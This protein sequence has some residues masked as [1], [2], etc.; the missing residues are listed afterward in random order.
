MDKYNLQF[1][2][3]YGST[4]TYLSVARIESLALAHGITV[5]WHPFSVKEITRQYG[6]PKGPFGSHEPKRRY[7][8]RDLERRARQHQLPYQ[9]PQQYPVD[10]TQT[11]LAGMVAA[12]EG[13]IAPYTVSIFHRNFAQQQPIGSPGNLEAVLTELGQDVEAVLHSASLPSTTQALEE[14]TEQAKRLGIF[15][16]PSFIADGELFW[17]DDRLD[18]AIQWLRRNAKTN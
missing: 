4:Y 7:M 13:W 6:M 2:F 9:K 5:T 16:S 15:G 12:T 10:Y 18:D 1:W 17:G 8:W 11:A 3:S 14:N